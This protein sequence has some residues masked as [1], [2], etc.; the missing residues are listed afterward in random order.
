MRTTVTLDDELMADAMEFTGIADK[1]ALIRLAF[2]ALL[3]KEASRRLALLG[4]SVPDMQLA[5]R[6]RLKVA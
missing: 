3:E 2:V 1:S 4:G 6:R 5:R